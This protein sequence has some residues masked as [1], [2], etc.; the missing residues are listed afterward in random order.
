MSLRCHRRV[1]IRAIRSYLPSAEQPILLVPSRDGTQSSRDKGGSLIVIY[2]EITFAKCL[3]L[4][5]QWFQFRFSVILFIV[6]TYFQI[7]NTFRNH[8][9]FQ[10]F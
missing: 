6:K 3:R 9:S 10:A 1:Y 7:K 2:T 4:Q 8:T 5:N